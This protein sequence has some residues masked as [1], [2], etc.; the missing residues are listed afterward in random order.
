MPPPRATRRRLTTLDLCLLVVLAAIGIW[1]AWRISQ[2]QNYR[3]NWAPIPQFFLRWDDAS[4]SWVSN[5]LLH[6]L[7]NTIRLTIFGMLLATLIG[8]TIGLLRVARDPFLRLVARSYVEL[9]RN[10]P[11][12]VIIFVLYFFLSSQLVPQLGLEQRIAAASPE[13][14]AVLGVLFGDPRLVENFASGLLCLALFEA[15]YIAEIVRAGVEAIGRGQWE[16]A[17]S[18]GLNRRQTLIKVI[19]P[20]AFARM[21]PPLCNQMVSLVKD[22]SI[23]SLVSI[24]ELTFMA[25][26]IGV[27]TTRVYEIWL[28]VA[29]IYFVLCFALSTAFARLERR[30]A[31]QR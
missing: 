8:V 5:L 4:G 14:R 10:T 16:A 21:V 26:D 27:S 17:Q 2:L 20:Q 24:Q 11:P 15:A 12:L 19:L 28:T 22:S 13:T 29:A 7:A 23:V 30:Y 18:L 6:G 25:T 9:M 1:F 31:R 3:W